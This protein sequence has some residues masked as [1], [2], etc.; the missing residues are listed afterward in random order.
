MSLLYRNITISGGVACGK[1]TLA[2]NLE[3]VLSKEGWK[4][5]SGSELAHRFAPDHYDEHFKDAK[6]QHHNAEAY[7]DETDRI[8]DRKITDLIQ[9]ED[10]HIVESWLAGFN[11]RNISDT[12]RV[13][14]V[15][16]MP[17]VL[18]DRIVNR[19]HCT[20]EE[21]KRHIEERNT[22]NFAKWRRIYGD[23]NFF[24]PSFY[25][26]VIDTYAHGP[27]ETA[28]RVLNELGYAIS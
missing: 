18:I 27:L 17:S 13:L 22:K 11:A 25:T 4:A 16:S 15:S 24:S 20:V 10:H 6:K 9:T 23:F 3:S 2:R 28:N 7:N 26:L 1:G 5:F 8:I 21:A 19:D 14:L 12:L